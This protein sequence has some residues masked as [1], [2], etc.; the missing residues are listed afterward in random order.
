M[1]NTLSE[2]FGLQKIK[3]ILLNKFSETFISSSAQNFQSQLSFSLALKIS[4]NGDKFQN[5]WLFFTDKY[6]S[7]GMIKFMKVPTLCVRQNQQWSLSK[8]K[9]AY[10]AVLHAFPW[11]R[12]LE[13]KLLIFVI[14]DERVGFR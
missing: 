8:G 2:F 4:T 12:S 11:T 14:S 13:P 9:L 5:A 1:T 3:V 7:Q 6:A 10:F